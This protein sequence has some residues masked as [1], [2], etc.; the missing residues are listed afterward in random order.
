[1]SI[2][3]LHSSKL[4]RYRSASFSGLP[5]SDKK[6]NR[7]GGRRRSARASDRPG[8]SVQ[9]RVADPSLFLKGNRERE[10]RSILITMTSYECGRLHNTL[11]LRSHPLE[12]S[13]PNR[14]FLVIVLYTSAACCAGDTSHWRRIFPPPRLIFFLTLP[15][16]GNVVVS[17]GDHMALED[18]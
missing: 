11:S 9:R 16:S 8:T 7:L 4:T 10:R 12:A 13:L 3:S 6:S 18:A 17:A 2:V 15:R 14:F 1:M 5:V